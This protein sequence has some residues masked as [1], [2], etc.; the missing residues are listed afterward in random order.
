[1]SSADDRGD[2]ETKSGTLDRRCFL[3]GTSTLAVGLTLVP[4]I[5][6]AAPGRN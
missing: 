1:M 4:A 3:V 2:V 6:T 5:R